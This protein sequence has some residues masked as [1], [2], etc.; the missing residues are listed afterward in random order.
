MNLLKEMEVTTLSPVFVNI[1]SVTMSTRPGSFWR[2]YKKQ[3][4]HAEWIR[5]LKIIHGLY[6]LSDFITFLDELNLESGL[7]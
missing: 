3:V 4:D 6:K 5:L 7:R 1:D 2:L